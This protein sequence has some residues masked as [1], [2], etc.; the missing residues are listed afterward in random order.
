MN[1]FVESLADDITS[2][3]DAVLGAMDGPREARFIVQSLSPFNTFDLF[4][5]LEAHR[6]IWNGRARVECH[7]KVA[8]NLWE[9]WRRGHGQSELLAEMSARGAPGLDDPRGWIDLGDQLTWYRNRTRGPETDGLVTVLLGLNHASDQGGLANFHIIDEARLWRRMEQ[10]FAPWI[11]RIDQH[12]GLSASTAEKERFDALLQDLFQTRPLQLEQL[13]DFLRHQVLGDGRDLYALADVIARFHAKLP[14][15]EIPPFFDLTPDRKNAGLL[16]EA[17]TFISHQRFKTKAEQ[18]KA[19]QKIEQALEED[20][21]DLPTTLDDLPLYAS[22]KAYAETLRA[23]IQEADSQARQR[24]LQTDLAP[25]LRLLKAKTKKQDPGASK[26]PV[27]LHGLSLESV[28]RAIWMT[29]LEYRKREGSMALRES[30]GGVRIELVYFKHDLQADDEAGLGPDVLAKELLRACLGGLVE[31][32]EGIDWRLPIDADQV[33]QSRD[34]WERLIPIT[35]DLDLD[36]LTYGTNRGRPH[37]HFKVIL[38]DV[39]GAI[40]LARP[41]QWSLGPTQPERVRRL[42]A[43]TVLERWNE[44]PDPARVLPAFQIPAVVL[45]ALYYA[46]DADEANRLVSLALNELQ[47]VDL[48]EGQTAERFDPRLWDGVITLAAAYRAWLTRADEQGYYAATALDLLPLLKAY[49]TLAERVLDPALRGSPELL[50]RLYKAFLVVDETMAPNDGFLRSAIVWAISPPVLELTLARQRFLCD[51][52]PEVAAE[53]ALGHDG[54]SAFEQLLRLAEIHRPL[55][56]LV[57]DADRRLCAEIKSFGLL[58]HLGLERDGEKSLAVQTLLREEESDDDD[59]V[60]D[61]VRRTEES[62]VVVR[63]LE[64]YRQLYPFAEDGMRILALHVDE[65]G[66]ILSGVDH[67]LRN[68]LKSSSRD[69]PAFHCEVMVYSTSASPLAME[70]RLA[71]WRHQ[72]A[73]AHRESGRPLV[74]AVGH[75]FAPDRERMV[76]LLRQERRLYDIA[77]L[78]HFLAGELSGEAE[79]ARPFLFDFNRSNIGQFPICEFPRP[80]RLGEPLQRQSLLSNRRLR[81]QT[82]HADLT[83]R[84]RHPRTEHRDHLIFG[85]IDYAPWQPVVEALHAKAQ[86]VACVDPFVDKHLLRVGE[87]EGRRKIVGFTSGLGDYGELNLSISTEQD[88][89]AQLARLVRGQLAGL[90]PYQDDAALDAMAARVVSEAEEVIGLA[91]LRAVVGDGERVRE[92]VGFA[93]IRRALAVPEAAM[94]QL[95]PVDSLL[96][97]FTGSETVHRPDLLQLSLIPRANDRPLVRAVVIECKFAQHNPAHL[98]KA[99]DQVQEGLAHLLPLLAPNRDDLRRLSFDRRYWWSQLQRAVT[100]RAVVDLNDLDWRALDRALENLSEGYYEIE[101]Q[102]AIFTFWT[103]EPGAEPVLTPMKLPAGVVAPPFAAPDDFVVWHVALGYDGLTA[104]FTDT[105]GQGRVTLGDTCIRLKP[106]VWIESEPMDDREAEVVSTSPGGSEPGGGGQEI[107]PTPGGRGP[108]AGGQQVETTPEGQPT[109]TPT[110]TP[111]SGGRGPGAGGQTATATPET[112]PA[113]TP[114]ISPS[115][116]GRGPRGVGQQAETT[117]ENQPAITPTISPSPGGRGPRG[118]GQQAETTPE[119]QPAI[120]Q[121]ISPSPGGR[122]PGGGGQTAVTTPEAEPAITS[123]T[124]GTAVGASTEVKRRSVSWD[125]SKHQPGDQATVHTSP[126][127]EGGD[128]PANV[129]SL[130]SRTATPPPR[131][132]EPAIRQAVTVQTPSP[133]PPPARGGGD[134]NA[135]IERTSSTLGGGGMGRRGEHMQQTLDPE[136]QVADPT[137]AP[138]PR[139]EPIAPI[140]VPERLLIG[141]RANDEPVYWHYGDKRLQNRHLLVFGASGSGK[142]YGIQCLLAEMAAQGLRSLIIDYT[143]GF[144]PGQVEARFKTIA[145]PKDHFVRTEKLPLNP[146]RCQRQVIDP[147]L[148]AVEET[149]YHVATRIASIFTSVFDS[150]GDQQ[151]A[152]LIRVIEAGVGATKGFSLSQLLDALHGDGQYG[153][154]LANKLEPL[155]KSQPFREGVDSAWEGMMTSTD[156]WVH[157]LQLAGLARDI[158]RMVTEFALWDL[159][160]YA[161]STGSQYRPIPV[162]LD[163]IQNLD[164]SSD[165][166]IDKMLREGRK[167]GLSMI[168]ATQTTSQFNQE[169]RDRLFMAGHKLFFKPAETEIDRFATLLSQTTGDPKTEWTQRLAKLTKGQC[170]SLGG[171]PTSSG[172]LQTKALLVNVTALEKRGFGG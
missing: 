3:W 18:K 148:P 64:D 72:L 60:T 107:P 67:F 46:A 63:V 25:V 155:I 47:V 28:L 96:H 129:I 146:F 6:A 149:P 61:L 56:G 83:A 21:L 138:S 32:L 88:T 90:M 65:L 20:R 109:I 76:E 112:Q 169:Q 111:S 108:G 163:E 8:T 102:G 170:W 160:D 57:V 124:R 104:L 126:A 122:G 171:V 50:R 71:A 84:L 30:L 123:G 137:R 77:F 49:R 82:C 39:D 106:S 99:S 93:A 121:N 131:D 74:L 27:N 13:S 166:P 37:L 161:T 157:V 87:E 58:H 29:L 144:L 128:T 10:G 91:A 48:L 44:Q 115:P 34:D 80:I 23:F 5:A 53:L 113:I 127:E 116:G 7:F 132:P 75:R 9:D 120:S 164:H 119:N 103:N 135:L 130:A 24:L 143:D 12:Y 141:T 110:I 69:W 14:F 35:L 11:E 165:S 162:V 150:I 168:L 22:P 68:Y 1:L 16:R 38:E 17:A 55:A 147:S 42:C 154:S 2:E 15:W 19:W 172:G 51:G 26:K 136:R 117:P 125:F 140:P 4:A 118:V 167:F 41:Y 153:E 152:A 86:W 78:F 159:Y 79:Q 142:T 43:R 95:L 85:R 139:V 40:A 92:V 59:D 97:W 158:Q 54:K 105:E 45:T 89:L 70:S 114:T 94:S 73:E 145:K 133:Q 66:T 100:S 52:F 33:E 31:V 98:L 62:A 81:A 101:W 134:A 36:G 151:K 156:A